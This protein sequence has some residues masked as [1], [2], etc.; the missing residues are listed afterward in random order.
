MKN[1]QK[2][3]SHHL[4]KNKNNINDSGFTLIE[5]VVAIG[6]LMIFMPT[7]VG[8]MDIALSSSKSA[9]VS[10]SN[11]MNSTRIKNEMNK[12][13]KNA[14]AISLDSSGTHLKMKLND[15]SCKDWMLQGSNLEY[16]SNPNG[17]VKSKEDGG[18]W[19]V[20]YD[21][22]ENSLSGNLPFVYNQDNSVE[23]NFTLGNDLNKNDISGSVTPVVVATSPGNC[24]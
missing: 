19:A 15:G 2:T 1:I 5:M 8:L 13:I 14:N 7:V 10:A 18:N 22:V 16:S 12:D 23:Y 9:E 6:I 4:K 11:I 3:L 20:A 21:K 17:P 24:W